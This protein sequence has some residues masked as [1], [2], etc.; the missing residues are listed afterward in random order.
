MDSLTA[1]QICWDLR[2]S[3]GV[4]DGFQICWD[5]QVS[6]YLGYLFRVVCF[7]LGW[8]F[9]F[10]GVYFTTTG[11][12]VVPLSLP[13]L[14]CLDFRSTFVWSAVRLMGA[15][16]GFWWA[17]RFWFEF[18]SQSVVVVTLSGVGDY[19]D[20]LESVGCLSVFGLGVD[21]IRWC[22]FRSCFIWVFRIYTAPLICSSYVLVSVRL[23]QRPSY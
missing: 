10:F 15:G 1:V 5:L 16:S 13:R 20:S 21:F 2:D 23:V 8:C 22:L 14:V 3:F 7:I 4:A 17:E 6:M 9:W 11:L 12:M 18:G 19:S